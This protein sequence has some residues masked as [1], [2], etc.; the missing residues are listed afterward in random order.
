MLQSLPKTS[1]SSSLN[2]RHTWNFHTPLLKGI[3]FSIVYLIIVYPIHSVSSLLH[4]NHPSN[5]VHDGDHSLKAV[6][7]NHCQFLGD[8]HPVWIN[9]INTKTILYSWHIQKLNSYILP[10]KNVTGIDWKFS[11]S[12]H[13]VHLHGSISISNSLALLAS[14]RLRC[15]LRWVDERLELNTGESPTCFGSSAQTSM[16]SITS[17]SSELPKIPENEAE[18]YHNC[19]FIKL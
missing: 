9:G 11:K 7:W 5:W 2:W 6:M 13:Q 4:A 10:K 12:L 16:T 8:C 1:N 19:S 18:S 17:K 14:M 15:G 3:T